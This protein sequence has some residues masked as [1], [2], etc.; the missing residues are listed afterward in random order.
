MTLSKDIKNFW[1]YIAQIVL[2]N[3]LASTLLFIGFGWL[4]GSITVGI[5]VF[6]VLRFLHRTKARMLKQFSSEWTME[7][8]RLEEVPL[9]EL[10]WLQEQ[11]TTLE[12]LGFVQLMDYQRVEYSQVFARCFTHPQQ[13]CFAVISQVV[14]DSGEWSVK[15]RSIFSLMEEGWLL[16]TVNRQ[17]VGSES[18]NLLWNNSKSITIFDLNSNLNEVFQAHL[19]TRQQVLTDLGITVLTDV[20]WDAYIRFSQNLIAHIKQ[21]LSQRSLLVGMIKVTLYELNSKPDWFYS[22]YLTLAAK[23]RRRIL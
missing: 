1:A 10:D 13:Y 22:D 18:W 8:I 3:A 2:T 21:A 9:I 23:R 15:Q 19:R 17:P 6:W 7:P 4:A 12:S 16:S 20:S 14:R 11:T 5:G